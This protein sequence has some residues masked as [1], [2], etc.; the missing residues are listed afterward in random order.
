VADWASIGIDATASANTDNNLASAC[1]VGSG[2]PWS[3]C[4]SG[5][6]WTYQPNYYPSGEQT[7]LSGASSNWGGYDSSEMN[8]LITADTQGKATLSAFEQY[9]ADQLP[10]LYMPNLENLLETNRDLKSSVVSPNTLGNFLPEYM[11]Y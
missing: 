4:W 7:F 2:T 11:H 1:T 9:A 6:S 8:S 3:I 5:D 10:V